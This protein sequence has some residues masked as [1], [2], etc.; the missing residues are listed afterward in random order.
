MVSLLLAISAL[1]RVGVVSV[2]TPFAATWWPASFVV[3]FRCSTDRDQRAI[4]ADHLPDRFFGVL[5]GQVNE[6]DGVAGNRAS[7]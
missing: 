6:L 3:G 4:I 2:I 1:Y 5:V 7:P